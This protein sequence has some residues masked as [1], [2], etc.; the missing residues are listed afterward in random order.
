MLTRLAIN[1][2]RNRTAC[3]WFTSSR[4]SSSELTKSTVEAEP[5]IQVE[6]EETVLSKT[7][8]QEILP[9]VPIRTLDHVKN[10]KKA[11][12]PGSFTVDIFTGKFDDE[13]LIY[14]D[15]LD[16]RE[17]NKELKTQAAMVRQLY[18]QIWADELQLQK[19]N[20]FNLYQLSVSEM[21]TVFES[22]G[23]GARNCYNAEVSSSIDRGYSIP[24]QTKVSKAIMSL[25]TRN[26]LTYWP[27]Y[28]SSNQYAKRLL[29]EKHILYGGSTDDRKLYP[30]IG[31][32][33][34]EQAEGIGSLPPQEWLSLGQRGDDNET[35]LV[36]GKKSNILY[37]ESINHFL[38]FFRDKFL[39]EQ[40]FKAPGAREPNPASDPFVG[41]ALVEKSQI[42]M[43][44]VYLN[45]Y[46]CEF[47]DIEMDE[48][49]PE[50][51]IVFHAQR[52]DPHAVNVKALGQLATSSVILGILKDTLRMTY[53]YLIKSKSGLLDCDIVR[54]KLA[55]IT[56]RIFSIESMVYYI[57]G[58]YD[59]LEDGFDAHM[60]STILKVIANEF[61]FETLR[62]IQH[63]FGS[64]IFI[65][66]K[67]QDQI[68]T[69][70]SFLDGNIFNRLYVA[71]MGVIWFARSK[72]MEL[73]QLRLAPWYPGYLLKHIIR[74]RAERGD[75]L[76]LDSDIQGHLHPSLGEA[77]K[78]LEYTVKRIKYAT[79][80][81]CMNHG[82]NVTSAQSA[83]YRLA[84]LSMDSFM[85][86]AMCARASK[87]YC[88]GSRNAE[89]D[90][91]L[92]TS[93]ASK[94]ANEVRIYTEDLNSLSYCAFE[95]R[96]GL[97]H[98]QNLKAGGYYAESPLDPNI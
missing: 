70:D 78:D 40:H 23:A 6:E 13:F 96:F 68:N 64:D 8:H 20:F 35:C 83:L 18:P 63:I 36:Q 16:N 67:L 94:I 57:S 49:L 50:S 45:S 47:I 71:T 5:A 95:D 17:Q 92:T 52:K 82:R 85:L 9:E 39:S 29:P 56:S 53:Q 42:K 54:R 10:L 59:G 90:V 4:Y 25:I 44:D 27:I 43:S 19:Y 73:N 66:S 37:E 87:S 38:V 1:F 48:V 72:N 79:E 77:A 22:V 28:K 80:S 62:D 81:L 88:N 33:W 76:T 86:T 65:M 34:T 74:E 30:P 41:C 84:Q 91:D 55:D 58:M 46:G 2:G 24:A 11:K 21:M 69:F 51:Q 31:F 60:E 3:S 61:A 7:L 26:C 15:V 97:I 75:Y 93:F 14:P 89:I 12:K 32:C 98:D